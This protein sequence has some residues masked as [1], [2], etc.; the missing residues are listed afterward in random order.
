MAVI[1]MEPQSGSAP[2]S[3]DDRKEPVLTGGYIEF[4]DATEEELAFWNVL[5][6]EE[7]KDVVTES[8]SRCFFD[9]LKELMN[10]EADKGKKM[11]RQESSY[12]TVE[13]PGP[14][15]NSPPTPQGPSQPPIQWYRRF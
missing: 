7:K 5:D 6:E 3:C 12:S 10:R 2:K 4:R 8:Y 14:P 1:K 9:V 11:E 13:Q 15:P